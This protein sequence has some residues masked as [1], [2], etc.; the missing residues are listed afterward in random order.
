MRLALHAEVDL[1]RTFAD[2]AALALENARLYQEAEQRRAAAEG[3]A[4]VG[5][6]LL[7]SLEPREVGRRI[8]DSLREQSGI[9]C[10][11]GE[12]GAPIALMPSRSPST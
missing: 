9:E 12:E 2:Q 5:S 1:A 11:I 10:L 7:R 6:L 8:V 3:L 4:S